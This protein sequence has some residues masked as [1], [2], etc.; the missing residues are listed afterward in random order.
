MYV[1]INTLS[2]ISCI[3][4]I[5]KENFHIL[6][7]ACFLEYLLFTYMYLPPYSSLPQ[8]HLSGGG[9]CQVDDRTYQLEMSLFIGEDI[10][11]MTNESFSPQGTCRKTFL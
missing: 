2:Y 1:Y 4:S 3:H 8:N 5:S 11:T 9:T 6:F 10:E 7:E